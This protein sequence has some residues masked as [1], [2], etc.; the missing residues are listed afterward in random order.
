MSAAHRQLTF[1]GYHGTSSLDMPAMLAGI[2]PPTDRNNFGG[3]RQLGPGFYTTPD[4]VMAELFAQHAALQRGG[5]PVVL[6]VYA[7]HFGEM[8]GHEVAPA[9]WGAVPAEVLT[10][11]DYL[12]APIAGMEW[13]DQI[14]FNPHT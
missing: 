4:R 12:T 9:Q 5:T 2:N 6:E 7:E 11:Y 8:R 13:A 1:V 10:D 3:Y 14:K